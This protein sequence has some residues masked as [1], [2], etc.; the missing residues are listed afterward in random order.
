MKKDY[1]FTYSAFWFFVCF[2]KKLSKS[3]YGSIESSFHKSE[4]RILIQFF[5]NFIFLFLFLVFFVCL[6]TCV[7]CIANCVTQKC[8]PLRTEHYKFHGKYRQFFHKSEPILPKQFFSTP[9]FLFSVLGSRNMCKL[10]HKLKNAKKF[11]RTH[12]VM[13]KYTL[14][15]HKYQ[16]V[17][18]V[19]KSM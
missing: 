14:I 7:N 8:T 5:L 18:K 3:F 1:V 10:C 13:A 12:L 11:T 17:Y 9:E 19:F 2:L 6:E 16:V 15:Y 4:T